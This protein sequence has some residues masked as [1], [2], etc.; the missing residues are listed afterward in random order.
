MRER[1]RAE[2]AIVKPEQQTLAVRGERE[3]PIFEP[4]PQN[5]FSSSVLRSDRYRQVGRSVGNTPAALFDEDGQKLPELVDLK[6]FKSQDTP[7]LLQIRKL[8]NSFYTGWAFI[9]QD[10]QALLLSGS[11]TKMP[12]IEPTLPFTSISISEGLRSCVKMHCEMCAIKRRRWWRRRWNEDE[13][14]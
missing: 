13:A 9:R 7:T 11:S 4:Q 3:R 5:A 12:L 14:M 1:G 6:I 10:F 2:T 8:E